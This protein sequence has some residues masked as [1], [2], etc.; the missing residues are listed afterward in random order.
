MFTEKSFSHIRNERDF[1]RMQSLLAD[2]VIPLRNIVAAEL[3][4]GN[5]IAD[6]GKDYPDNGSV[7]VTMRDRFD[8]RYASKD[9]LFSLCDDPHYW[10]A[11]YSSVTHPRHLLIC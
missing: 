7:H 8:D 11:D 5:T 3:Q 10:H 4:R 6:V 1:L 2:L 9:A